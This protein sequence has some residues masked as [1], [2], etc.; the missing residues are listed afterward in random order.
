MWKREYRCEAKSV[1][2]FVQQLSLSYLRNGYWFYVLGEVPEGKSPAAVDEK[3]LAK[4][5]IAVSKWT[6]L[7]RK[8]LG[9]AK[10]QYLRH[11]RTF[12]LVATAGRHPFFEEERGILDARETPIG[13]AGYS[14]SY[15]DGHPHVRIA[16]SRFEKL[17]AEFEEA[18]L[19][20][21]L[22]ELRARFRALPFEPYGPVKQQYRKLLWK[23]N[24]ARRA[25]GL[26]RLPIECLRLVR[27]SVRPFE[28]P[29]CRPY[30][31]E[32]SSEPAERAGGI[33]GVAA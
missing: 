12:V 19:R 4:Y 17:K 22:A 31:A 7:R 33:G 30:P 27:R 32:Y 23:V 9:A 26:E 2:G 11:A 25:A 10:L 20:E 13:F 28:E 8:K 3:L 16:T 29:E 24:S 6:K 18:A 14:I 5:D 21:P 15:K 1:A